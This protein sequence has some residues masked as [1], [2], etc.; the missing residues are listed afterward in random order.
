VSKTVVVDRGIAQGSSLGP[1]T[2]I[3]YT[4][5]MDGIFAQHDVSHHCLADDTQAYT[6]ASRSQASA[7]ANQLNTCIA[8]IADWCG[9]HRLQL[10]IA[11]TNIMRFVSS[12][13]LQSIASSDRS[14]IVGQ[15]TI[16]ACDSARNLSMQLD[17]EMSMQAQ[18]TKTM[19]ICFFHLRHLRQVRRLLGRQVAAQLV[20]AFVISRLDYGNATLSG[21]PLSTLAP[22]PRVL[23]AAARLVCDL[24]PREHVTSALI[25]LHWLPVAARIEF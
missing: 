19:Q 4:E 12:A 7:V 15:D 20:S 16:E 1:K 18:I 8:D 23:N 6:H 24:H 25:D 14:V 13:S 2:F 17:C 5:E 9:S 22:L 10:N 11:K 21:L 3:A